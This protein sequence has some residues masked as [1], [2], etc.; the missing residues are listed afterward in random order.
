MVYGSN[1]ARALRTRYGS[2]VG[3][4]EAMPGCDLQ[5]MPR[6]FKGRKQN[7][8]GEHQ[9]HRE[10]TRPEP[11]V[12]C[13]QKEDLTGRWGGPK[14]SSEM[15]ALDL[16]LLEVCTQADTALEGGLLS[17]AWCLGLVSF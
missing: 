12:E 7:P 6:L 1:N 9:G 17:A 15:A 13:G 16:G 3:E 2:L 14:S 11:N 5:Q 10:E 4:P 8:K